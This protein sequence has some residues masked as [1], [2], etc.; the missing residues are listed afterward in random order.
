MCFKEVGHALEMCVLFS[1]LSFA[2]SLLPPQRSCFSQQLV[3]HSNTLP[4]HRL[5]AHHGGLKL[6]VKINI[7][8]YPFKKCMPRIV[9][10]K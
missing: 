1:S 3:L 4:P 6:G 8:I 5:R 7:Y 9:P 10:W 2:L